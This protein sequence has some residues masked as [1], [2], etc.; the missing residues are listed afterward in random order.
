MKHKLFGLLVAALMIGQTATAQSVFSPNVNSLKN[1][2]L[3]KNNVRLAKQNEANAERTTFI[4]TC[5]PDKSTASIANELKQLDV[6]ITTLMGNQLA[7]SMPLSKLEEVAAVDGILL[8]DV[9]TEGYAKTD[10]SRVVTH[11][12]EVIYGTGANLPQAYTGKGVIIGLID[13]GYDYTHPMFKDKDGKLRI[14]GVYLPVNNTLGDFSLVNIPALDNMG[15]AITYTLPGSFITNP[16]VILDTLKVKDYYGSHG[17]YCAAAAAGSFQSNVKGLFNGEVGGMAPDADILLSHQMPSMEEI[18]NVP[19][20]VVVDKIGD[21]SIYAL[22]A[23][24]YYAAKQNKPLVV[25]WSQNRH[26]GFHDGTST[27]A[28]YIGNYCKKGTIVA[29]CSSN[30]GGDLQ[31]INRRINAGKTVG[32]WLTPN[33]NELVMDGFIKT[34]KEIKVD[35]AIIDYQLKEVYRANLPLTSDPTKVDNDSKMFYVGLNKETG[36]TF[37]LSTYQNGIA[38]K[39]LDY[40]QLANIEFTVSSGNGID[41]RNQ[42]YPYVQLRF[43]ATSFVPLVTSDKQPAYK[44]E[45]S[46]TSVEDDVDLYAWGDDG[47]NLQASTMEDPNR[48]F[49]GDNQ[50]SIGDWNT[51]GEPVTIGAW[52]ANVQTYSEG[53]LET[54]NR[55]KLGEYAPFSSFG[56]DLSSHG[57]SYPDVC[58]PGVYVL[59]PVSSFDQSVESGSLY[60]VENRTNQFVGQT[61]PRKYGY[62]FA[63]GTSLATPTAAGIFAL[64]VQAAMDVNKKLTNA[65][66]KDI[67]AHSSDTDEFTQATPERFGCGKINAYK[68]LL[69]VLG[70]QTSIPEL[71]KKHIGAT[72]D[73]NT[74]RI[75]GYENVPVTL[76]NL[77]GQKVFSAQVINGEVQLPALSSGVYAVKIG[78]QG[79]TLIRL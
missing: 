64:W 37:G 44:I 29:L 17:T 1:L 6:E 21:N 58:A 73:G 14:K 54:N 10:I 66:I 7:V 48:Y 61:T 55:Y 75:E 78:T 65:D 71:P 31:Y 68:G 77:S 23:M 20:K 46:V 62:Q 38:Q 12:N 74:L 32:I 4:L 33:N 76:Y 47:T 52:T 26:N 49:Y 2:Y 59:S 25:S 27:M 5:D 40:F 79:S 22:N 43:H 13:N 50:H 53:E 63:S 60:A 72:L 56:K 18:R 11:T 15:E 67:I 30:E 70:T 41:E 39:L 8:I 57:R 45:L 28:R 51:S 36:Q 24:S 69:Y 34:N 9:P 19:D 42:H 3:Q 35:L 16:Q